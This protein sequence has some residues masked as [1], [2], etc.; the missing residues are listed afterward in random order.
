EW[1]IEQPAAYPVARS[2]YRSLKDSTECGLFAEG[3]SRTWPPFVCCCQ[4]AIR[5][6]DGDR[7]ECGPTVGPVIEDI[8]FPVPACEACGS[9]DRCDVAD[10]GRQCARR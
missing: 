6:R 4:G 9:A 1:A 5:A 10:G 3:H 7:V 2:T 8:R